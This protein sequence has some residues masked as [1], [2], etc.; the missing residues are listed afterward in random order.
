V[1]TSES[2]PDHP[3]S[4]AKALVRDLACAGGLGFRV[5]PVSELLGPV[6]L[7]A[8]GRDAV[9]PA[10]LATA[11]RPD[12]PLAVLT[13]LWLLGLPVARAALD[14]A[15]PTAGT[16]GAE[17]LG[18]VEARG[19]AGDDEVQPLLE[20]SPYA[21]DDHEWWL[22]SDLT[23][24]GRPLRPDHVLGVGGA[25]TTLARWTPRTR[26]GSAL[27]IGTGCG[28]QAFHLALH[29]G[30]VTATDTS[31]RCLRVARLNALLNAVAEAG[32]FAGRTLD[33]RQGS[34]LAPVAGHRFD[35]VVS[36]PPYVITPRSATGHPSYPYRDG[37]LAGDDIVRDLVEQVGA[38]L[39]EGGTAQLLGNWEHRRGEGWRD[40]I[41]DWLDAS[42]LHGWVVQREVQDPA[43]YAETWARDGGHLP[44]TPEHEG[45]YAAWLRDFAAREVEAIGFGVITLRRPADGSGSTGVRVRRVEEHLG[46]TADAL[47][48]T[49]AAT[50]A[51][52]EWLLGVRDAELL[53]T[54]LVVAADV[55][56]ERHGFPGA[57]DP[58]VILLRKGGGLRRSVRADTAL[59]AVVG[60]CDGDL[61]VG[62]LVSAVADLTGEPPGAVTARILPAVRRLVAD[63]LLARRTDRVV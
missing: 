31:E 8:L 55:N 24:T 4:T 54:R 58:T 16:A 51:A 27:D 40:R 37:G 46:P 22:A 57:E 5:G 11:D 15:L 30:A 45:M 25:S 61:P 33:L 62:A 1:K 6:A 52:E 38:V 28:V 17:A 50:L 29:A 49:V 42:G 12:D 7:G 19:R 36:N 35:L 2:A 14:Q 39:T 21:A 53:A 47:G 3:D 44:G 60:A 48:P 59:A 34:L 63:G 9:L 56:E 43:E 13:R 32:P 18:L 41:G 23:H 20:L 26:V 10:D